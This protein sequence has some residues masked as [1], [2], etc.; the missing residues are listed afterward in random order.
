MNYMENCCHIRLSY[1]VL[2][3]G[4]VRELQPKSCNEMEIY[5]LGC[6]K[7]KKNIILLIQ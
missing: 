7:G 3:G 6:R 5:K 1:T 4:L 2:A